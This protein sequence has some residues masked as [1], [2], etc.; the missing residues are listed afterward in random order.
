MPCKR[1][2]Q[3]ELKNVR[4][5]EV[6]DVQKDQASNIKA[7]TAKDDDLKVVMELVK[8]GW[9]KQSDEIA[10]LAHPYFTVRNELSIQDGLLFKVTMY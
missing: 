8:Q 1:D 4:L 2:L 9:P 3:D 6:L 7:V 5:V 10:I